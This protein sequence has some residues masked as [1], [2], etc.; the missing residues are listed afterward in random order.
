ME[1]N[2]TPTDQNSRKTR[3][4]DVLGNL[5]EDQKHRLVVWLGQYTY[6]E[7]L[8]KI[9]AP[10][11][12]GLGLNVQYTSLRRFYTKHLPADL[13]HSRKE[14]MLRLRVYAELVEAEPAPYR[15]LTKEALE[16]QLFYQS[17]APESHGE[18]FLKNMQMLLNLR[19]QELKEKYFELQKNRLETKADPAK[20][21]STLRIF[22]AFQAQV[23]ALL[24]K[25]ASPQA[26]NPPNNPI[27]M[28]TS[29]PLDPL[30]KAAQLPPIAD[31]NSN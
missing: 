6:S 23:Q 7:V 18:K 1:Q 5:P 12:E 15:V 25:N 20:N 4:D 17:L 28:A 11:P 19:A 26:L 10:P 9:A 2:L 22:A 14:E 3:P 29:T 24:G 30:H 13:L 21:A 27:P 8:Q 16:R 31:K